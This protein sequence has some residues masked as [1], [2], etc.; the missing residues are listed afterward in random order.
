MTDRLYIN[1]RTGVFYSDPISLGS[2]E[3]G[4]IK[5]ADSSW[6]GRKI[7]IVD[8]L[9]H[10]VELNEGSLVDFLKTTEE[11]KSLNK[12]FLG[13]NRSENSQIVDAFNKYV[14]GTKNNPSVRS[15]PI[16]QKFQTITDLYEKFESSG[17][18]FLNQNDYKASRDLFRELSSTRSATVSNNPFEREIFRRNVDRAAEQ[19]REINL[20]LYNAED[21]IE[22]FSRPV[23]TEYVDLDTKKIYILPDRKEV[24]SS[25]L[26]GSYSGSGF[27]EKIKLKDG[28]I[29]DAVY[30]TKSRNSPQEPELDQ[31]TKE[32]IDKNVSEWKYKGYKVCDDKELKNL[33]SNDIGDI[34]AVLFFYKEF[35][36]I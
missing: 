20:K 10:Q 15:T 26:K 24:W 9:G 35:E 4:Q 32:T 18:V 12:G 29:C 5:T 30:Y 1:K 31:K 14:E 22:V 27:V 6:F 33:L 23:E 8:A 25:Y 21:A 17:G 11:G 3:K 28:R 13:I 34:H 7:K 2:G 36:E 19:L 16:D